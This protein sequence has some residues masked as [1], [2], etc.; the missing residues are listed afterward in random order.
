MENGPVISL[1]GAYIDIFSYKEG[2]YEVLSHI[3]PMR[4]NFAVKII[5]WGT[6]PI[7]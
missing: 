4:S 1:M 7:T 6:E 3:A 2:I 5:G